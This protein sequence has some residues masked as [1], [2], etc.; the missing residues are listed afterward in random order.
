MTGQM[1][2]VDRGS[3]PEQWALARHFEIHR[4]RLPTDIIPWQECGI[5]IVLGV[6]DHIGDRA[7]GSKSALRIAPLHLGPEIVVV[8]VE[9]GDQ[10]KI[11]GL[12]S[13]FRL[14]LFK[15]GDKILL[16]R[17]VAEIAGAGID[18]KP[19]SL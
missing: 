16:P 15:I 7:P 14:K 1:H 3:M 8:A 12:Q 6:L 10:H 11:D 4:T 19:E 5:G 13:G 9:M 18:Q 2:R 17:G